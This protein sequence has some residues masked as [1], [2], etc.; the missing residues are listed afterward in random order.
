M[1]GDAPFASASTSPH[2][3]SKT[4]TL[5]PAMTRGKNVEAISDSARIAPLIAWL[6]IQLLALLLA[7]ARVPLWARFDGAIESWAL[8]WML[9]MQV[10]ASALL[11]P[12]LMSDL[13]S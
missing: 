2:K 7:A 13:R 3:F 12:W 4:M 9:A 1:G 11:F 10:G 6:L 5:N 8:C